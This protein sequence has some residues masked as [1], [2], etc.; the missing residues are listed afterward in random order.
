MEEKESRF[1][2]K[3]GIEIKEKAIKTI[4]RN[5]Y[6]KKVQGGIHIG[7]EEEYIKFTENCSKKNMKLSYDGNN[8]E[9][10]WLTLF[11]R[12][13]KIESVLIPIARSCNSNVDAFI[14]EILEKF[15]E[16]VIAE[17]KKNNLSLEIELNRKD[18]VDKTVTDVT[19]NLQIIAMNRNKTHSQKI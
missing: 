13:N 10:G 4:N 8:R 5:K 16:N 11:K 17:C 1:L 7:D 3:T 6:S 2:G 12:N 14:N 19:K 18:I 9:C 15:V